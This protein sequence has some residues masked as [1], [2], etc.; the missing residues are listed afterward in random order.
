MHAEMLRCA[1]P[2][3][4]ARRAGTRAFSA[5]PASHYV[6]SAV[7]GSPGDSGAL[8]GGRLE[9]AKAAISAKQWLKSSTGGRKFRLQSRPVFVGG[10]ASPFPQ[11]PLFKPV[12]PL[13]DAMR[14]QIY[15]AYVANPAEKTPR[16]LAGE[17]GISM[18]R[19][20]AILRLKALQ[21]M[22][23]K[24]G[25]PVQ[26]QLTYNM[27][28]LLGVD[29]MGVN[30]V[31]E[32]IYVLPS[33]R[34]KP[35]FQFIDEADAIS[36]MDA[37]K[38]LEKEPYENVQHKLDLKAQGLFSLDGPSAV[39]PKNTQ[40]QV[41]EKDSKK[42]SMHIF[43]FVDIGSPVVKTTDICSGSKGNATN[44]HEAGSL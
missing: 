13:S 14:Q 44:G 38:L 27:E 35:L 28:K 1:A 34:L 42:K 29:P 10:N 22:N 15:D 7:D 39:D 4:A 32:S 37:A 9:R 11:N 24:K 41:L 43:H 26:V 6:A 8:T 25:I 12:S 2:A 30:R 19:V 20:Q 33:E 40:F 3:S 31:K 23:E 36:P 21:T 18:V 16:V 5:T 17:F